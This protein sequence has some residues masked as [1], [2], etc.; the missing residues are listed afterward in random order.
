MKIV[1]IEIVTGSYNGANYSNAYVNY[2]KDI[3]EHSSFV[4]DCFGQI[5]IKSQF[6]K[7][8]ANNKGMSVNDLIG[9][10]VK[11]VYYNRYQQVIDL[12]IE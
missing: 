11:K 9:H 1:G 3:T 7:E 5:K 8:L 10:D 2:K 6:L 4:G 12:V